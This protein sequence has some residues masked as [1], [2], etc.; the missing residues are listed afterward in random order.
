[1]KLGLSETSGV[2]FYRQ[3]LTALADRIRSGQLPAGSPLPSIREL[4]ADNLVSV[5]TVKKAYEEL[6]HLG[7][8]YSHQGRGTFVAQSGLEASRAALRAELGEELRQLVVRARQAG[9]GEADL[10]ADLQALWA[11][12][13][14]G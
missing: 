10:Q 1:M 6:E 14:K 11:G 4:A 12:L 5:I 9:L 3:V 13:G 7:L 2:P 8:I